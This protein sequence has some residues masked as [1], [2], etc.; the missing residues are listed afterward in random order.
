MVV[1]DSCKL[2]VIANNARNKNA[3][4]IGSDPH[5]QNQSYQI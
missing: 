2:A 4:V 5:V 1:F 3:Y